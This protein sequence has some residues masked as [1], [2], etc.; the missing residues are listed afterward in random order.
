MILLLTACSLGFQDDS[1][2]VAEDEPIIPAEATLHRL[3]DSQWRNAVEDLTGHRFTGA[4]PGDYVIQGYSAVGAAEV[5]IAPTDLELF[6]TAAWSV[7]AAVVADADTALG[8]ALTAPLGEGDLAL[9]G[10]A[11]LRGWLSQTG[12]R[13]W[14]RPL[15]ELELGSLVDLVFGLLDTTDSPTLAVQGGLATLLL[16]PHF[17]FRVERGVPD[18]TVPGRQCFT[19]YEAASR[20]SFLLWDSGPDDALLAAAAAG[21]LDDRAGIRAQAERLLDDPRARLALGDFWAEYMDLERVGLVE[22]DASQFPQVDDGLRSAMAEE[23]RLLFDDFAFGDQDFLDLWTTDLAWVNADLGAI[24]GVSMDG[25]AL[26]RVRLTGEQDRGG[27][28]GRAAFLFLNAHA[29][30]NSPTHRGRFVRD[31]LL[32][33]DIPP[34]PA[35]L[36]TSLD[37]YDDGTLR[38]KL[39]VHMQDPSC[40]SCHTLMDPIGFGM[41]YFDPIGQRRELDNDLP[42][43]ATGDLDGAEFDG[44]AGLGVALAAHPALPGCLVQQLYRHATG[45]LARGQEH[46]ALATF[47]DALLDSGG[48]FRELLLTMVTDQVFRTAADGGAAPPEEALCDGHDDDLDGVVDEQLVQPCDSP[49]GLGTQRCS[50]GAWGRCIGPALTAEVCDGADQDGDGAVDEGLDVD[51]VTLDWHTLTA[52]HGSC[53]PGVTTATGA[54]FAATHRSCGARSCSATGWGPLVVDDSAQQSA[55]LCLGGADGVVVQT[56]YSTLQA[57]HG[58][59]NT[60][61]PVGVDCNASISRFCAG[62]GLTTGFG[63]LEYSGDDVWVT[64]TPTANTIATTYTALSAFG[65]SCDGSTAR[66]DEPCNAAIHAY[67]RDRGHR[68]GFGPLENYYDEAHVAC[69]GTLQASP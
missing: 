42:I 64:C 16:S 26:Q 65:A 36:D 4:L 59:C 38:D 51:V 3:T 43:D 10:T 24:Y 48:S 37:S 39:S 68:S 62:E 69:V 66:N 17:L 8:C 58:G 5:T 47:T 63:P 33:Q 34:P 13:A 60:G 46:R 28:L 9:D 30:I 21:E 1:G 22:K 53:D 57:I 11:C 6:E 27:L 32:C 67:C 35:G 2:L 12:T 50:D 29:T 55:V 56:T 7:A 14:R 44:A 25:D 18:P 20:L 52:A 61:N 31:T 23:I 54:C 49:T 45:H 15:T 41:E 19:G 40:A